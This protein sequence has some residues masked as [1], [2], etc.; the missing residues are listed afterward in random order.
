MSNQSFDGK[1]VYPFTVEQYAEIRRLAKEQ[2]MSVSA[3]IRVALQD[4]CKHYN[5]TLPGKIY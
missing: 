2:Q 1:T 5:I 3:L 4:Y